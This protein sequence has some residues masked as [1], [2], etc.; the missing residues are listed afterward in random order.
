MTEDEKWIIYDNVSRKRSWGKSNDLPQT[1][2]KGGLRTR[3][4]LLSA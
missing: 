3:K 2:S 4:V 1:I